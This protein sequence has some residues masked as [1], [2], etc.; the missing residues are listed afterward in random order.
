MVV[1]AVSFFKT[2]LKTIVSESHIVH[3]DCEF[4]TNNC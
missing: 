2:R 1:D 3:F 4:L